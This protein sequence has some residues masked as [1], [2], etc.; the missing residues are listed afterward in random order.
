MT[1]AR[2]PA[3][4]ILLL[5]LAVTFGPLLCRTGG[6]Q[7]GKA[8]QATTAS[9][10]FADT[11]TADAAADGPGTATG[12]VGP[13]AGHRADRFAVWTDVIDVPKRCSGQHAPG[14]DESAPL[15]APHRVEPLAPGTAGPAPMAVDAPAQ[16]ALARPP[17]AA[18]GDADHSTLLPVL[19]I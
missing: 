6:D 2:R 16:F 9:S 17:T 3:A 12:P 10:T 18:A 14:N 13:A 5:L 8:A 4:A 1:H 7:A 15:P 11:G 19:R